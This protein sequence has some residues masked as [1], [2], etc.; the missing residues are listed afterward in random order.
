MEEEVICKKCGNINPSSNTFCGNCGS[1][2][3]PQHSEETNSSL[4][5]NHQKTNSIACPKCHLTDQIQKLT[6]IVA[7]GTHTASGSKISM[8]VS[9]L[10]GKQ[11]HYDNKRDHIGDSN[12]SANIYTSNKTLVNYTE[13]SD[14]V[15]KISSPQA[16]IKPTKEVLGFGLSIFRLFIAFFVFFISLKL[17]TSLSDNIHF[18]MRLGSFVNIAII[19]ISLYFV[20]KVSKF[21]REKIV[22]P[23]K[24]RVDEEYLEKERMFEKKY[25]DWER[26]TSRWNAMYY[27]YRDDV[28]FIP[29][30]DDSSSPE[31]VINFCYK[32]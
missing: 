11:R 6:S 3:L 8:G 15:K 7:A 27:C 30:I 12:I 24:Q 5:N 4:I 22:E 10:D 28:V 25:K 2:L 23:E 26:A 17:L 14:L 16:P 9:N 13:T 32:K 1:S 19:L 20:Y 21:I 31:D 18:L 29:G